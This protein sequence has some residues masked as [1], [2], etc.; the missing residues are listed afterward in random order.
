MNTAH[1]A[2]S[3]LNVGIICIAMAG[4]A[5]AAFATQIILAR[6]LS[7]SDVGTFNAAVALINTVAAMASLG[8]GGYWLSVYGRRRSIS[9]RLR[10]ASIHVVIMGSLSGAIIA[11]VIAAVLSMDPRY[12][13][14][15]LILATGVFAQGFGNLGVAAAQVVAN[16]TAIRLLQV[17]PNL[18]RLMA[19]AAVASFSS[20][21]LSVSAFAI[22]AL[23]VCVLAWKFLQPKPAQFRLTRGGD[24]I[25]SLRL[26][27]VASPYAVN[28]VLNVANLQIS[29]I[30]AFW[31]YGANDAAYYSVCVAL[32]TLAQIIPTAAFSLYYLPRMHRL[33]A[34]SH[35]ALRVFLARIVVAMSALGILMALIFA[36]VGPH[37]LVVVF[38][39]EYRG[40]EKLVVFFAA[41]LP[42][43]YLSAA[44]GATLIASGHVRDKTRCAAVATILQLVAPIIFIEWL[45]TNAVVAGMVICDLILLTS[46]CVYTFRRLLLSW[47]K[48]GTAYKCPKFVGPA[49]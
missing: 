19:I 26:A 41:A 15:V 24:L 9:A 32:L 43:R 21:W 7:V 27:R 48:L 29:T 14:T 31:L 11:A 30:L 10:A 45:T 16:Q 28:Q 34:D 33:A 39:D 35:R 17:A 44:L 4:S 46:L 49:A 20:Y 42:L 23:P 47:E 8:V 1:A 18:A 2:R 37:F 38:G 12:I 22:A 25:R 3:L 36:V 13:A 6:T 40:A 5:G